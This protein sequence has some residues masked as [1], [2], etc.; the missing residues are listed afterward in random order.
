M[1]YLWPSRRTLRAL[2]VGV[3]AASVLAGA[4]A[5]AALGGGFGVRPAH[6][7]PADPATRAYFKPTIPAGGSFT[8]QVIVTNS[9]DASVDLLVSAVDGLTGQTSGAVYANRDQHTVK[10]ARWVTPQVARLV[11]APHAETP[12]GF[13][14]RVP[15]GAPPGDH[16]AGIAFQDA[17]PHGSG[18]RF[19]VTEVIREVVGVLVRVPGAAQFHLNVDRVDFTHLAGAETGAL[20]IRIGDDGARLGKAG[21][22]VSLAGPGGYRRTVHA[23]LD[24]ILPGDTIRYPLPWPDTLKPGDYTVSIVA[25]GG[26]TPVLFRARLH[27]GT[28]LNGPRPATLLKASPARFPWSILAATG[29]GGVLLGIIIVRLPRRSSQS[30]PVPSAGTTTHPADSPTAA[31]TREPAA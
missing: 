19:G 10:A 9:G 28:T 29:L 12:V 31:P 15:A 30:R 23:R 16:L 2:T 25:S 17:H 8:D 21:L 3:A 13:T 20:R 11:V 18:A 26:P 27:L 7:D 14:V 6:F 4:H 22:R 1:R 5:F 24:T